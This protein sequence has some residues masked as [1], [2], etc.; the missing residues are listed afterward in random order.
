MS[1]EK[2]PASW[3][4]ASSINRTAVPGRPVNFL[5]GFKGWLVT[6]GRIRTGT[7][8][9]SERVPGAYEAQMQ[10]GHAQQCDESAAALASVHEETDGI[11]GGMRGSI[12]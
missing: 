6:D 3:C 2:A 12:G 1:V 7:G 5:R 10:G 4:A 11:E 8:R 9:G